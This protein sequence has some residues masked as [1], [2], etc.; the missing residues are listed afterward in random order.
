MSVYAA[1]R[2]KQIMDKTV[3]D[4]LTPL[5]NASNAVEQVEAWL[6]DDSSKISYKK[7]LVFMVLRSLLNQEKSAIDYAANVGLNEWNAALE[8]VMK[9]RDAGEVPRLHTPPLL[10]WIEKYMYASTFIYNQ[11]NYGHIGP[12]DKIMLDCG[13]FC[14][15]TSVWAVMRGA[16]HVYAFEPFPDS[17][18]CLKKNA[19]LFGQNRITP[20]PAGVGKN[21]GKFSIQEPGVNNS[22]GAKI[23]P[24]RDGG[25]NIDVVSLDAWCEQNRVIPGFIKMDVEG[26]EMAALEGARQIIRKHKPQLA[27]SLYYTMSDM[28]NIPILIK[29][30]LPEYRFWCRKNALYVE[31]VLYASVS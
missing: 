7:E 19:E 23:F 17:L 14:G 30:I 11:Y 20:V 4:A 26:S 31:F 18:S 10:D 12:Q 22:Y 29:Q 13:A 27:V 3:Q 5:I 8:R 25:N 21:A 2:V 15:D 1:S 9:M 24:A 6:C 28:W 16:R